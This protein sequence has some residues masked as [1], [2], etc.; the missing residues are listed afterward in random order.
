MLPE[1]VPS[2]RIPIPWGLLPGL[3]MAIFMTGSNL[4]PGDSVWVTAYTALSAH[5]NFQVCSNTADPQH[6]DERHRTNGPLVKVVVKFVI[7]PQ[8][9]HYTYSD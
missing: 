5:V 6:S 1:L 4:Y 3:T 2:S 8:R 9:N 7:T